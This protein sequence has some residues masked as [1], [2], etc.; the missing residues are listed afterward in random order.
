MAVA[1]QF[2]GDRYGAFTDPFGHTWSVA[3]RKEDLSKQEMEERAKAFFASAQAQR[4]TA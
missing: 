4:K 2:W 3:T 1:D